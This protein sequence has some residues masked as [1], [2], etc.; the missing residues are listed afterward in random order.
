MQ[1]V[2]S[3]T[4]Q[5]E[6]PR[7]QRARRRVAHLTLL[8]VLVILATSCSSLPASRSAP[9]YVGIANNHIGLAVLSF[10]NGKVVRMLTKGSN[11]QNPEVSYR[12]HLVY[13]AQASLGCNWSIY[14]VSLHGGPAKRILRNLSN[15][16]I[17]AVTPGGTEVAYETVPGGCQPRPPATF[18]IHNVSTGEN[19][20]VKGAPIFDAMAWSP[21]G[22][23]LAVE[24]YASAKAPDAVILIHPSSSTANLSVGAPEPCPDHAGYCSEFSPSFDSHGNLFYIS[25]LDPNPRKPCDVNV[26]TTQRYVLTEVH[27]GKAMALLTV[28]AAA[29]YVPYL[30]VNP[31]GTAAIVSLPNGSFRWRRGGS[32]QRSVSIREEAW[33]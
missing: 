7:T 27:N 3:S 6:V 24:S 1:N 33:L 9:Q 30:A 15:D 26:C 5:I 25:V 31:T 19:H 14:E 28:T 18:V 4:K 22:D 16:G 29:G 23:M 21:R 10:A 2:S 12:H 8:L 17:F 20:V 32:I 11:D 13:F